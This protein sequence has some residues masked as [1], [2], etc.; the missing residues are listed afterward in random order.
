MSSASLQLW[1]Y[2]ETALV[3]VPSLTPA[4][5]P[6][7]AGPSIAPPAFTEEQV[8][9][10]VQY[11]L[12]EAEQRWAAAAEQQEERRREQLQGTLQA[13]TAERAR[14]FRD[15]ETEVVHLALAI[16]RKILDREAALDPDLLAALVRIALDRMGAGSD[17]KLRVPA[18][19]LA[20]WQQQKTF[21]GATYR[22]DLVPDPSLASGA[23]TVET[24]LG[25][26]HFGLDLQFKE[27][28]QG[29]LDLLKLRPATS[30]SDENNIPGTG[31]RC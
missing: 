10:R 28:E 9:A 31:D 3:V 16:A 18:A 25:T 14:Y 12:Q 7:A 1:E 6:L 13:F 4:E 29:M 22:C 20:H 2:R 26:G 23:C 17:V 11:A 27:I 24:D 5:T 8:A 19:E 21:A 30:S 15:V